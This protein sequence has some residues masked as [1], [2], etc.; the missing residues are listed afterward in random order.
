[1]DSFIGKFEVMNFISIRLVKEGENLWFGIIFGLVYCQ[2]IEEGL[3][4]KWYQKKEFFI[5]YLLI[6]SYVSDFFM[7]Q[8]NCLWV[9]I[10]GG[11]VNY[12][13]LS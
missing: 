11:G 4:F 7:D 3:L 8:L 12:I 13:D 10:F 6:F 9:S 5:K 1:M 2:I